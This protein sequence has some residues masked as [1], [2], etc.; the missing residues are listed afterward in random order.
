MLSIFL[1]S[2]LLAA[3]TVCIHATGIAIMLRH[4]MRP[5]PTALFTITLM[6][7][8][9]IW[10]LILLHL[11]EISLWALF[12]LWRGCLPNAEAAFYFSGVTYTTVGYG[13]VVLAK[14]WRIFAPLEGLVGVLMCGLSMG[15]FFVV[16]THI[17]QEQPER[18]LPP[19]LPKKRNSRSLQ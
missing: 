9:I 13:D 6:L 12:Y 16:V 4:W 14:P 15:Y 2:C 7:L 1:T 11:T 3:L 8:H 17:H 19:L 10:W 18:K 5:P